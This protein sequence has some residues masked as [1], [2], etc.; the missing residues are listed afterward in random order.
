MSL[1]NLFAQ[2]IAFGLQLFGAGLDGLALSLQRGESLHVEERLRLFAGFQA[3]NG[4]GEVF[5]EVGDV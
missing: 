3:R 5:S 4:P 1:P 2:C